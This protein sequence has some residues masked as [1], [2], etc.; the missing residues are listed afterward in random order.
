MTMCSHHNTD[1][2]IPDAENI[3]ENNTVGFRSQRSS[4]PCY[5]WRACDYLYQWSAESIAEI[6]N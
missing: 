6:T 4:S 1:L 5:N 2:Y 3:R